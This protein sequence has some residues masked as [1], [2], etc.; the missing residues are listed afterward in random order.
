MAWGWEQ[1]VF[2]GGSRSSQGGTERESITPCQESLKG[3]L[4]N[5]DC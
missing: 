2:S 4:W 1:G 5:I 3:G